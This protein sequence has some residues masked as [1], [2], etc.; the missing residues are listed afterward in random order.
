MQRRVLYFSYHCN[1]WNEVLFYSFVSF[2]TGFNF[3]RITFF[4]LG[5]FQCDFLMKIKPFYSATQ[6]IHDHTYVHVL[7]ML[8]QKQV[9]IRTKLKLIIPYTS[10]F[11][12][13]NKIYARRHAYSF[14]GSRLLHEIKLFSVQYIHADVKL[15]VSS[16]YKR[17][18]KSLPTTYRMYIFPSE[19]LNSTSTCLKCNI[20]FYFSYDS[21]VTVLRLYS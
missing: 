19:H 13:Y 8:Q 2:L 7:T 15:N 1:P 14:L 21:E 11:H 12:V 5:Q 3:Y 10:T 9:Y 18:F 4:K 6:R 20:P 16:L 17:D